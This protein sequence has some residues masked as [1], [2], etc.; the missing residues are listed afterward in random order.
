M[1]TSHFIFV[2]G[3]LRSGHSNHH[4]LKDACN[5]GVGHTVEHFAMYLTSGYPYVNSHES[6]YPIT[7]ELLGVDDSTLAML[8]KLEGH[9]RY[10]ERK[11]VSII[12]EDTQYTAWMY[13][14]DPPGVLMLDG[15]Y[16]KTAFGKS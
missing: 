15:D 14:K 1:E 6:R 16:S 5:Y 11:E 12:V 13:F 10:Y 4:L 9:P 2:Y 8:D 7:G 3:T